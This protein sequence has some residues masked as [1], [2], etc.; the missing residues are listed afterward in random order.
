MA[1]N[2]FLRKLA[3]DDLWDTV[4]FAT[5]EVPQKEKTDSYTILKTTPFTL[6][7]YHNRNIHVN[8]RKCKSV[9]EVRTFIQENL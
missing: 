7:I 5:G 4:F 3:Q 1:N 9:H 2:Y 8:G 6:K